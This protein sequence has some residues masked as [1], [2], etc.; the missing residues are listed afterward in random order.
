MTD[1]K[2]IF[3]MVGVGKIYPPKKQVLKDIYLSFFYGAKIGVLGLNGSGKSTLLRIIAGE[4]KDYLGEVTSQKGISFGYLPQEPL[5]D[6]SRTVRQIV[7]EGV[8]PVVDLLRKYE[9]FE[10]LYCPDIPVKV[11]IDEAI[12]LAKKFGTE[13]SRLFIN[14]IL[15]KVARLFP[16]KKP[17]A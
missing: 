17:A 6:P 9:G 11:T 4:E 10:I 15:D 14:G 3:S 13:K 7:E 8:Q 16:D 1:N 12:E 2:I 5:L